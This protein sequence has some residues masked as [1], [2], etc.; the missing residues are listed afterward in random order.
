MAPH[1]LDEIIRLARERPPACG[2][3]TVIAVD[4]PSGSGKTS[5]TE[6]LVRSCGAAVLH[7]DDIYPGWYGL[8]ATP[9]MVARDVLEPIAV[10][11]TGSISRWS[12]VRDRPGPALLVPPTPLLVLDG[13]GSGAAVIRPFL[14][15]LVWVEAPTA[16]RRRRALERDGAAYEPW[17]DTW[18]AGESCHF[19]SEQ[20]RLHADLVID[21]TAPDD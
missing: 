5:L 14:S 10:G 3:T 19:D 20:T 4:G 15:V 2:M 9:P 13:V 21:T 12:W 18:A 16:V 1:W 11:Q 7:L 6:Q 8:A 17:W